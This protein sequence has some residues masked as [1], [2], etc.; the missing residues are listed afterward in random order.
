MYKLTN[1]CFIYILSLPFIFIIGVGPYNISLALISIIS[2][3]VIYKDKEFIFRSRFRVFYLFFLIFYCY[4]VF[5][6]IISDFRDD[7]FSRSIP[8][9]KNFFLVFLSDYVITNT[10]N[11]RF[12]NNLKII[13]W[14]YSAIFFIVFIFI[15][16]ELLNIDFNFIEYADVDYRLS[17]PFG[18]E[19]IVGSFILSYM[20]FYI[21]LL[22][23]FLIDKKKIIIFFIISIFSIV[24]SGER[25][26]IIMFFFCIIIYLFHTLFTVADFKRAIFNFK[27]FK[28]ACITIIFIM[29]FFVITKSIIDKDRIDSYNFRI[30]QTINELTDFKNTSYFDHFKTG[31]YIFL[32]NKLTGSGV[33]SFRYECSND[34]YN[35]IDG[36]PDNRCRTHPH[37]LY[38]EILAETGI[39][40]L[41]FLF[42]IFYLIL[43]KL[44]NRYN[45]NNNFI[46]YLPIIYYLW[47]IKTS[48]SF[49]SSTYGSIIWYF[50]AFFI[51]TSTIKKNK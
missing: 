42:I 37:N 6:S 7:S 1:F 33:K 47:P 38:I 8:Y 44:F 5:N 17:G 23:Y 45:F 18:K 31:Y 28:I 49:F 29:G 2:I 51:L 11:E 15:I 14:V 35:F 39:L 48:G 30:N 24:L 20:A 22:N 41:I 34:I 19:A 32:N 3:Y 4:L 9:I 40:G 50:I 26:T 12:K 16:L 13:F 46:L 21:Y 25:M 27:I 10:N 36:N 43:S